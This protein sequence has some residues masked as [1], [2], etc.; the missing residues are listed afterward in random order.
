MRQIQ[1]P[2]NVLP[3][4]AVSDSE[5]L[6]NSIRRK[7][8]QA[9]LFLLEEAGIAARGTS[10]G[11]GS[12]NESLLPGNSTF[13]SSVSKSVGKWVRARLLKEMPYVGYLN[14][15]T[16]AAGKVASAWPG[17][18]WNGDHCLRLD[19]STRAYEFG[20]DDWKRW[21]AI[22]AIRRSD[23]STAILQNKKELLDAS[24]RLGIPFYSTE[25]G[26]PTVDSFSENDLRDPAFWEMFQ[27]FKDLRG[28]ARYCRFLNHLSFSNKIP[29]SV[30]GYIRY[31]IS[32]GI[33]AE[34]P[35]AVTW[36]PNRATL[37]AYLIKV[38]KKAE[39][40]TLFLHTEVT[41]NAQV[42]VS[43]LKGVEAYW[44]RSYHA[45]DP[46]AVKVKS[47]LSVTANMSEED[48]DKY[49]KA[50]I[51]EFLGLKNPASWVTHPVF[52][53]FKH[54]RSGSTSAISSGMYSHN[55]G[56]RTPLPFKGAERHLAMER[57]I[58]AFPHFPSIFKSLLRKH[59]YDLF[60]FDF[61]PAEG[62]GP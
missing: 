35:E 50:N 54:D 11:I 22:D 28:I 56:V 39:A 60:N 4:R 9:V 47:H 26:S 45:E 6:K 12:S 3:S 20:E 24:D 21:M 58:L 17:T 61:R 30:S 19:L 18:L 15:D 5:I 62:F 37:M 57:Y 34:D 40:S 44:I 55:P 36:F 14:A 13:T 7:I 2:V 33:K 52:N 42:T 43:T 41:L 32:G 10:F 29:V 49:L 46:L 1:V 48:A 8:N 59:S 25:I 27:A 53:L 38:T 51:P 31:G 16:S 23:G